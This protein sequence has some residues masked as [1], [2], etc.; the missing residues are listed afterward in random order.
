MKTCVLG[1]GLN[2]KIVP[3][4]AIDSL[5]EL[6]QIDLRIRKHVLQRRRDRAAAFADDEYAFGI[7]IEIQPGQHHLRVIE[8]QLLRIDAA[9]GRIRGPTGRGQ[10]NSMQRSSPF[11]VTKMLR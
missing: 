4:D 6:D 7:G 2:S 1:P 8:D 9:A 11:W 10:R 3:R 5:V